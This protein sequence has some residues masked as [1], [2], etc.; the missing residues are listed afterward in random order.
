[1]GNRHRLGLSAGLR[2]P[3]AEPPASF[4]S[5]G[6]QRLDVD[7]VETDEDDEFDDEFHDDE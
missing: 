6:G 1:M 2:V 7:E 3:V 4:R 5:V